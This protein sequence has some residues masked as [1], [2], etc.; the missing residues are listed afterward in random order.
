MNK[1]IK[2]LVAE[3]ERPIANAL[4]LK[5]SHE[6]FETSVVFNG[7]EALDDLEVNH[8]DLLILDLMM[9]EISGFEVLQELKEK[10]IKIP[11]FISSNLSQ[12]ED[13]AK[14]KALG[15]VDFIVKSDT[16]VSEIILKIKK[17]FKIV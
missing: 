16:P 5:L 6:G 7:K 13:I 1:K 11:V 4:N 14:A 8:Y 12:A 2:I 9:P 15:A 3:D 17:Y 10:N